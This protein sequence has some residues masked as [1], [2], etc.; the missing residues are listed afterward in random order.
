MRSVSK[1]IHPASFATPSLLSRAS[2]CD[3][4]VCFSG[5]RPIRG[6]SSTLHGVTPLNGVRNNTVKFGESRE[7]RISNLWNSWDGLIFHSSS[8]VNDN[9]TLLDS[10]TKTIPEDVEL[11]DLMLYD[12][13]KVDSNIVKTE[14]RLPVSLI[15]DI[16]KSVTQPTVSNEQ[17]N[18]DLKDRIPI[19]SLPSVLR[20]SDRF[21]SPSR[22]KPLVLD[23]TPYASED[24]SPL[25]TFKQ[26][27]Q[28]NRSKTPR[29]VNDSRSSSRDRTSPRRPTTARTLG[30]SGRTFL[31]PPPV[32]NELPLEPPVELSKNSLP[33]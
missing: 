8:P 4:T 13:Q 15:K 5:T 7:S 32:F 9:L 10:P 11:E 23:G 12:E 6:A 28:S 22:S 3:A 29:S 17:Q 30:K 33:R 14:L 18:N 20:R 16:E 26:T 25:W 19:L 24:Y 21:D 27:D 2:T 1:E 31:A